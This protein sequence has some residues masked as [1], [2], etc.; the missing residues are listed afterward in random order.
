[1]MKHL[2]IFLLISLT[3]NLSA[4]ESKKF[5]KLKYNTNYRLGSVTL[6]NGEQVDG[7]VKAT[8]KLTDRVVFVAKSGTIT[9]YVPGQIR[10][11]EISG[12]TYVSGIDNFYKQLRSGQHLG[13]YIREEDKVLKYQPHVEDYYYELKTNETN[14]EYFINHHLSTDFKPIA[15]FEGNFDK[16]LNY[17]SDCPELREKLQNTKA[18]LENESFLITLIRIYNNCRRE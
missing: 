12:N 3:F 15:D 6:V 5:K 13:L 2:T 18:D 17:L 16:L 14:V 7:L 9:T 4:Q 1:M 8:N 10:S 11:F